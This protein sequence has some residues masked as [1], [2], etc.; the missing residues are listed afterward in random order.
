[1]GQ[2]RFID[3]SLSRSPS[4]PAVLKRL[5]N[6][7]TFLD[8]GCCFAQDI[9]K[10]VHD[11]A[12]ADNLWG[13]EL[14]PEFI[15][16]GYDLFNDRDNLG[17]HFLTANIFDKQSAL[18]Q[19]TNQID[20][21]HIGLF[22]HLFDWEGQKEACIAIVNL[23]KAER[24]VIVL[25][26]QVGSLQPSQVPKSS[27]SQMFKHDPISF[28][29]LWKEVG[30][31]TGTEWEVRASLD[32]GLGINDQKRKWDDPNTRRLIFEVERL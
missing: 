27:G 16:L 9:R 19:L 6:G 2:L 14:M 17:A 11:G 21:I 12:P 10:L 15:E 31:A 5:K 29:K 26:Q 32:A 28:A 18:E 7:A 8:I 20:I 1:M 4:Y 13:A 24:G 22:L 3:L 23:L 25:G 30:E